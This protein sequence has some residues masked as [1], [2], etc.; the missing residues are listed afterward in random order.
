[1]L[2]LHHCKRILCYFE[3]LNLGATSWYVVRGVSGTAVRGCS[4]PGESIYAI[5]HVYVQNHTYTYT[6]ISLAVDP[7][8]L[9]N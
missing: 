1:M 6:I 7:N 4:I 8:S 2:E 5:P 9:I 3:L